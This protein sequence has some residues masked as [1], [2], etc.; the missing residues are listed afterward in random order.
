MNDPIIRRLCDLVDASPTAFHAVDNMAA[1]LEA[2]GGLCL[3]ERSAWHLEP[4]RLYFVRRSLSALIAFRPG[5]RPPVEEGFVLAGAHTDS[6]ALKLRFEKTVAARGMQRSPVEVYGGPIVS[7]WLD[8]P[9]SLAGRV[10][11]RTG[12]GR[13]ENRLVNFS[14]PVGV[15]PNLAIHLNR[16]LNKGFEYNVQTQLPVLIGSSG[17]EGGASADE[18]GK[19]PRSPIAALVAGELGVEEAAILGADLYF[20]DAQK[21]LVIGKEGELINGYRL[22]DLLGCH[23]ILEAFLKA[24]P[25]LHGQVACFLDNEEIGSRSSQG[26]DSSFTRDLLGR[27]AALQGTTSEGFYRALASSFSLSVDV[28][29]AWHPAYADKYDESYA[30]LLNGGPA[31]KVNANL[32]YATDAEAEARFRILCEESGRP[33]QKFMSRADMSPGSTIGPMSNALT[34]IRTVDIGHPLLSMHSIRETGGTRDHEAMIDVLTR[35]FTASPGIA[36]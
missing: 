3:D 10:A 24:E 9:L 16:D 32:R 6:P 1:A 7:T 14:R 22:D 34:G 15:I 28:A 23:A 5:L 25:S 17:M 36:P 35:A 18:P 12:D 13:V 33:C 26:A 21:T 29:Q 4:G 27:I 19:A 8:R 20:V 2:R 31:V 30:P 11:L